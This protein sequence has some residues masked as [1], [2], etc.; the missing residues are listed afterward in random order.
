MFWRDVRR[1]LDKASIVLMGLLAIAAF[2]LVGFGI[3][4]HL[5]VLFPIAIGTMIALMI[6]WV[7][8]MVCITLS[9]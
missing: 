6:V 8:T 7:I 9:F 3:L 1:F 4:L 2:S 5:P